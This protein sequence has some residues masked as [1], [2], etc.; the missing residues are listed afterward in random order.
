MPI[1]RSTEIVKCVASVEEWI[2]TTLVPPYKAST[3]M[4]IVRSTEIVKYHSIIPFKR[5]FPS[6][7]ATFPLFK[8]TFHRIQKSDS[9]LTTDLFPV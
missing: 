4:P 8:L 3:T 2:D 9:W 1:V 5:S 7:Q 6:C